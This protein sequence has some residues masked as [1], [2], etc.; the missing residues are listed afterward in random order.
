MR[1][2]ARPDPSELE[3][4][5]VLHDDDRRVRITPELEDADDPAIGKER[6]RACF[7]Q[8]LADASWR[9]RIAPDHLAG[10]DPVEREIPELEDFAHPPAAE[11]FDRLKAVELWQRVFRWRGAFGQVDAAVERS[12]DRAIAIDQAIEWLDEIDAGAADLCRR[13]H[14]PV[15][16]VLLDKASEERFDGSIGRRSRVS[17]PRELQGQGRHRPR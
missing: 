17:A 7:L 12:S 8:E 1:T 16:H 5:D 4:V 6:H 10:H 14:P 15:D 11:P 2:R 3:P 9:R 13:E